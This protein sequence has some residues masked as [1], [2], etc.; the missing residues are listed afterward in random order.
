MEGARDDIRKGFDG[1]EKK[2]DALS[3]RIDR[4]D[5]EML[6]AKVGLKTL[7]WIGSGLV[8]VSG[9]IGA[10]IAKYLPLLGGAPR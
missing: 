10:L 3:A 8:T 1:L 6:K 7:A 4:T 9:A 2:V 5:Q